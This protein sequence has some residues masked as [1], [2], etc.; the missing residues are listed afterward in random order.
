MARKQS[1]NVYQYANELA[2]NVLVLKNEIGILTL[3]RTT[4]TKIK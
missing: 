2:P 3:L 1:L 4:S